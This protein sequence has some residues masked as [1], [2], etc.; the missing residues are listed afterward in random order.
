V[1]RRTRPT[2]AGPCGVLLALLALAGCGGQD[3]VSGAGELT[4]SPV[5]A[6]PAVDDGSPTP[7]QC[8]TEFQF[9]YRYSGIVPVRAVT[10]VTAV[11]VLV[12]LAKTVRD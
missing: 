6:V 10:C 7:R 12:A 9:G 5:L 4:S 3:R 11:R 8:T 1:A 2:F